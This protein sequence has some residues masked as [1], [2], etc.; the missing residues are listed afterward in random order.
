MPSCSGVSEVGAAA[1]CAAGA[2]LSVDA[3]VDDGLFLQ[4]A[5]KTSIAIAEGMSSVL[6]GRVPFLSSSLVREV[7]RVVLRSAA[8]RGRAV[9]RL[10]AAVP[11]LEQTWEAERR[12]Q[13]PAALRDRDR[14]RVP[15]APREPLPAPGRTPALHDRG[16]DRARE[17]ARELRPAAERMPVRRG[18]VRV[19]DEPGRAPGQM[20]VPRRRGLFHVHARVLPAPRKS[21]ASGLARPLFHVLGRF[22]AARSRGRERR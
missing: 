3:V 18:R 21:S 5:A 20:T 10:L 22:H 14:A 11:A 1:D 17:A 12:R 19:P 16:R 6:I 15:E 2:Y 7:R 9:G 4:P 13:V 8:G